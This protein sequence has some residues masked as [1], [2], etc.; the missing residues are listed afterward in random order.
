[1]MRN[2]HNRFFD[3][4]TDPALGN[5][6]GLRVL[7][8][9]SSSCSGCG[10]GG[11]SGCASAAFEEEEGSSCSGCASAAPEE[12]SSC[13]SCGTQSSFP[14]ET[15]D[16]EKG[17]Y[18]K[19]QFS[20]VEEENSEWS[21]SRQA[22]SFVETTERYSG[23]VT[24]R[25]VPDRV[26]SVGEAAVRLM[27][28]ERKSEEN[29]VRLRGQLTSGNSSYLANDQSTV[30]AAQEF[31]FETVELL[32]HGR[33]PSFE[34]D[35]T[36]FAMSSPL[37]NDTIGNMTNVLTTNGVSQL[38][39]LNGGTEASTLLN[40]TKGMSNR[41]LS[42]SSSVIGVPT[43][44]VTLKKGKKG[45]E[46]K[47]KLV[48]SIQTDTIKLEKSYDFNHSNDSK[49]AE[50]YP[51]RCSFY[52]EYSTKYI[53][54]VT[55]KRLDSYRTKSYTTKECSS[56][57]PY[58]QQKCSC[59]SGL[60]CLRHFYPRDRA[61]PCGYHCRITKFRCC[62]KNGVITAVPDTFELGKWR[63]ESGKV[64]GATIVG[65]GVGPV[66]GGGK[67]VIS[68]PVY[69]KDSWYL[70]YPKGSQLMEWLKKYYGGTSKIPADVFD[71]T[72]S[73]PA[74]IECQSIYGPHYD[75]KCNLYSHYCWC[76]KGTIVETPYNLSGLIGGAVSDAKLLGKTTS[77]GKCKQ[78]YGSQCKKF[79][80]CCKASG[81]KFALPSTSLSN[82][83]LLCQSQGG[84]LTKNTKIVMKESDCQN[85]TCPDRYG[86][87]CT[88]SSGK[89]SVSVRKVSNGCPGK[90]N[91]QWSWNDKMKCNI[92]YCSNNC[93]LVWGK[94]YDECRATLIKNV[95]AILDKKPVKVGNVIWIPTGGNEMYLNAWVQA[96]YSKC[97]VVANDLFKLCDSKQVK[98]VSLKTM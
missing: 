96:E 89:V 48:E 74:A 56:C 87:C 21:S 3:L 67:V 84:L 63:C 31:D 25:L 54:D 68:A 55:D 79:R 69:A 64:S 61:H 1:M 27:Q 5:G 49:Y 15:S 77:S 72:Y 81:G 7:N 51:D 47:N 45:I 57:F 85:Q 4:S 58:V 65:H 95:K 28:P 40:L 37:R 86:C 52:N 11:Y 41:S 17:D 30:N 19:E 36:D 94:K 70:G 38:R 26:R 78:K 16:L 35:E 23:P 29:A 22:T 2:N 39:S 14:A 92:M 93:D 10:K 90:W 62:C 20:R 88:S 12:G 71:W 80:C 24:D 9:E 6:R 8:E 82:D 13:S 50:N 59:G 53:Y 33:Y 75:S 42:L 83:V 66:V 43:T 46:E 97:L 32:R 34:G 76:Q 44:T 91:R 60:R 18:W 73:V 98:P